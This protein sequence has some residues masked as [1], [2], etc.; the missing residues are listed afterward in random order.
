MVGTIV[1][2][3]LMASASGSASTTLPFT[4]F[5]NRIV[6]Q[7]TLD[8]HGPYAFIVDTGSSSLVVTPAVAR[9]LGLA[10]QRAGSAYGAGSG[11]AARS[12]TRIPN[13][14]LG[15][16]SFRN[17]DAEVLDLSTIRRA[18]GFPRL[19]GIIGYGTLGAYRVGVDMDRQVLTLSRAALR[20]PNTAT[21]T[22]FTLT[23]GL[24]H[25]SAAVNGVHGNFL[26]DTGDRWSLTLFRNFA[27]ANDFY[28]DAPV[29]NVVTG[30]GIGGPVYSDVLR[31]TVSVFGTAVAGVVTRAS[32]DQGGV[33]AF[34]SEAASIGNGLLKRFNIVYDYPD[35]QMYAWPSRFFGQAERYQPLVF[36]DGVLRVERNVTD[37]TIFPSPLSRV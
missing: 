16:L 14:R 8:G 23:D 13:V 30:I 6:V 9:A 10:A 25:I 18:I 3:T 35:K 7:A 5:D 11:S 36:Q 1:L 19:D 28:R 22:P 2:A 15:S 4:M 26:V 34:G 29:R 37:P 27:A 21:P 33:F 32:R 31:T 17:V 12:L 24:I 20:I